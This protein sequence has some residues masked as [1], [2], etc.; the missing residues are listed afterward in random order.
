MKT[1]GFKEI[2]KYS[3][4]MD[5]MG[6]LTYKGNTKVQ[7][8]Y[9]DEFNGYYAELDEDGVNIREPR[10]YNTF[11]YVFD[12]RSMIRLVSSDNHNPWE[13]WQIENYAVSPIQF[14]EY[15]IKESVDQYNKETLKTRLFYTISILE[16]SI[17]V[18]EKEANMKRDELSQI[19]SQISELEPLYK[20]IVDEDEYEWDFS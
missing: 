9:N 3:F 15:D 1:K 10:R 16:D 7:L 12:I 4:V 5:N 14:S 6:T 19:E 8:I 11:E 13:G 2:Y 20:E 18:N 17:K